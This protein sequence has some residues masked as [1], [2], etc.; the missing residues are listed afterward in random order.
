MD[1]RRLET[2]GGWNDL[3]E[4]QLRISHVTAD[5]TIRHLDSIAKYDV[6]R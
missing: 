1:P 4:K 6:P 2:G 5:I 3:M